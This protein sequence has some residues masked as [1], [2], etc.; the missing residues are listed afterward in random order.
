MTGLVSAIS[1]SS[2]FFFSL[3]RV[4]RKGVKFQGAHYLEIG[5]SL[6]VEM[7]SVQAGHR[8]EDRLME[9][10]Q[11]TLKNKNYA[12]RNSG[13]VLPS[14]APINRLCLDL[15]LVYVCAVDTRWTFL[16]RTR[17]GSCS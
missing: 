6:V 12:V 14:N 10:I 5:G 1:I 16:T 7:T 2:R 8:A 4:R 11:G 9:D 3:A 17:C 13:R 15:R